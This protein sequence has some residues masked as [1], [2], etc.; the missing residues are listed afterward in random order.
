MLR[1]FD[2]LSIPNKWIW[3]KAFIELSIFG[4]PNRELSLAYAACVHADLVLLKPIQRLSKYEC[5]EYSLIAFDLLNYCNVFHSV[6]V[7][8]IFIECLTY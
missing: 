8:E 7:W 4:C 5:L 1:L 6:I 2:R 3:C